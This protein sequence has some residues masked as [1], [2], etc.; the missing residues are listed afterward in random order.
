MADKVSIL[1]PCGRSHWH[2]ADMAAG[3]QE[4]RSGFDWNR[5]TAWLTFALA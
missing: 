5:Q 2:H 4:L 1:L 3:I